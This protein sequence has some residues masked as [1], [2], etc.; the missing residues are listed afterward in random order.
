[1][2]VRRTQGLA[3][4]THATAELHTQLPSED[5]DHLVAFLK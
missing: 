1:V 4:T 3:Q 2:I 5:I